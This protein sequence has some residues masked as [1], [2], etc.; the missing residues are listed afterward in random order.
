MTGKFRGLLVGLALAGSAP[1][2]TAQNAGSITGRVT[3]AA[4]QQ[5]VVSA[6]VFVT[7]TT[8][9]ALTDEEG[10]YRVANAPVGSQQVRVLR[11]GYT[12][13]TQA[14]TVPAQGE[15]TLDF[16]LSAAPS[17]LDS[18]VVTVTGEQ[19]RR[20]VANAVSRI[21]AAD[22][23]EVAPIT[24]FAQLL[25]ARA[26]GVDV[27]QS[28]GT[29]GGGSRIRIR[30]S[31]SVS[32]DNDPIVLVDGARVDNEAQRFSLF[33]GGQQPSAVNDINPDD[34]ES[35]EIVKGPSAATLYGTDAANGVVVI[36]TKRGRPGRPRWNAFASGGVLSDPME[37]DYPLNYRGKAGT[38]TGSPNC[39]AFQVSLALCQQQ[40]LFA[41][42]PLNDPV[43]GPIANGNHQ[44]YG[45]SV[46]GGRESLSYYISADWLKEVGTYELADSI[47]TSLAEAGTLLPWQ[48][49]PSHLRQINVRGNFGAQIGDGFNLNLSAGYN[50]S[51]TQFPHNDDAISGLLTSALLG[52]FS[53]QLGGGYVFL[54]SAQSFSVESLQDID[55]FTG[56]LQGTWQSSRLPW[57]S[58]RATAGLDFTGRWDSEFQPI[59]ALAIF[60]PV[61]G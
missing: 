13:A 9:G 30:G 26:T 56:S 60:G 38:T 42:Q 33:V 34:I 43:A 2:V 47:R 40:T 54:N 12:A 24:N 28:S 48:T 61:L 4:T 59:G 35:I 11:V 44:Q 16:A 1:A 32:L 51:R 29:I 20:E 18:V 53:P 3:D 5:P 27:L 10:R 52:T 15:V 46:S 8:R 17:V 23:V 57:L 21:D 39:F 7:G 50:T 14:V 45:L 49:H 58:A 6:Q 41:Y 55:R 31:N 19:R 22:L 36:T 37:G 25:N